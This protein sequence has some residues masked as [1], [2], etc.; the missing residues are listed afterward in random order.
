MINNNANTKRHSHT[1][2]NKRRHEHEDARKN[3]YWH[4]HN[5]TQ[6]F[7]DM[8]GEGLTYYCLT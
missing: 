7:A 2:T 1:N 6:R 5:Q 3:G 4:K 8:G